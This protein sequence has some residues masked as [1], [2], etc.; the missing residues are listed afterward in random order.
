MK[1]EITERVCVCVENIW[2][3]VLQLMPWPVQ[4]PGWCLACVQ[5]ACSNRNNVSSVDKKNSSSA[6][7]CCIVTFCCNDKLSNR[8]NAS[9]RRLHR[10][11]IRITYE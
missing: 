3:R 2:K 6:V 1:M 5:S 7:W 10:K 8:L 11:K 4:W 9:N